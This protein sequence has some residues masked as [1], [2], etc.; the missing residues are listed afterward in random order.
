ML[1]III[2][3]M[4]RADGPTC[5]KCGA[6]TRLFGT[7]SHPLIG[8]LRVLSYVCVDCDA[9][10]VDMAP[11]PRARGQLSLDLIEINPR[12]SRVEAKKK[13]QIP[14]RYG[15]FWRWLAVAAFNARRNWAN[16]PRV[17]KIS[18]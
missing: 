2:S 12:Q 13:V 16:R 3:P 1:N 5:R 10:R 8:Q 6:K 9:V 18:S 4:G 17:V 7:E 14:H 15:A 11:L